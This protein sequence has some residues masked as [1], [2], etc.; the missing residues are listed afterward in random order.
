MNSRIRT[1]VSPAI[2][3]FAI[4]LLLLALA[5]P[6]AAV[7]SAQAA[8]SRG[9]LQR[10]IDEAAPGSALALP[11]GR[12]DGPATIGKPLSITA[13]GE[14]VLVNDSDAPAITIAADGVALQGLT[15]RHEGGA[16]LAA[17]AVE[18][19][20]AVIDRLT[21]STRGYGILL[22]DADRGTITNSRIYSTD[23]A[24]GPGS[25]SRSRQNGIDLYNS[26]DAVIR[27][28]EIAD[29]KDGIYLEN[30]NGALVEKNRVYRSRYGIHCMYTEKTRVIGNVGEFNVTG[31]M[32]MGVSDAYV[33]DNSFR[34][35]SENV[36]SQGLLL[37]D[38]RTSRIVHNVV[39]GNRIGIYME[40]SSDNEL[41]GNDVWRNFTGVQLLESEGNRFSGNRFVANVVEAEAVDSAGNHMEQNYWDAFQGL[42]LDRDGMS[43]M[44][45]A[46]NPFYQRLIDR[47]PAFQLFFQSP[48]IAFL[49]GMFG[50]RQGDW[51]SDL[52]PL[53]S[54]PAGSTDE[55]AKPQNGV[56]AAV[57]LSLILSSLYIIY[58]LGV[59]RT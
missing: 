36:N 55:A 27:A 40:L 34:K 26:H 45:Y 3:C 25:G 10:L 33:A 57:S 20:D 48:G 51:S 18:A 38:V 19:G 35:Q 53:M 24:S 58:Y 11:A 30:S 21:V 15:I 23:E 42:D 14:A 29:M 8:E 59:R 9:N 1:T 39:E 6:S 22:R 2:A 41:A 7:A 46:M 56:V 32:I 16:R 17:V 50:D 13:D 12:Y 43:D 37:Y 52:S 47:T 49:S 4:L 28:N 44:P 31:G 54:M 5:P